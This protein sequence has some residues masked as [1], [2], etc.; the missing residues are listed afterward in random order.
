[1]DMSRC[2]LWK[3]SALNRNCNLKSPRNFENFI[4][5]FKCVCELVNYCWIMFNWLCNIVIFLLNVWKFWFYV[6]LFFVVAFSALMLLVGWHEGHP[7]CKKLSG[8]V[9]AWL[10]VWSEV[11][12][13]IWPSGCHCHSQSLAS[14][15]SRLVFPFWY[16]LTWLVLDKG[17]LKRVFVL[18]FVVAE[19]FC[20]L[21]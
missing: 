17:P 6:D 9:L 4:F 3:N 21:L 18:F 7:A 5:R 11:Q 16:Q 14:V 12:T 20:I 1:M 8:G 13:C 19:W 2:H 15:K 10:S